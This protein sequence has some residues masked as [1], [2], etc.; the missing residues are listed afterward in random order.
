MAASDITGDNSSRRHTTVKGV[1]TAP[2]CSSKWGDNNVPGLSPIRAETLRLSPRRLVVGYANR[3]ICSSLPADGLQ[4]SLPAIL[5]HP[6]DCARYLRR[7]AE[8]LCE[9]SRYWEPIQRARAPVVEYFAPELAKA[10]CDQLSTTGAEELMRTIVSQ[11]D[12]L[13]VW[14]QSLPKL[15]R[16]KRRDLDLQGAESSSGMHVQIEVNRLCL[17]HVMVKA[18]LQLTNIRPLRQRDLKMKQDE[19]RRISAEATRRLRDLEEQFDEA[20]TEAADASA[21]VQLYERQLEYSLQTNRCMLRSCQ[22][23]SVP[24]ELFRLRNLEVLDLGN[25]SI[26]SIPPSVSK[27][28][29]LQKLLLDNNLIRTLPASLH[30]LSSSLTL[31]ALSGNPLDKQVLKLYLA[32]LPVLM[33]A[34]AS[35]GGCAIKPGGPHP[36]SVQKYMQLMS[37]TLPPTVVWRTFEDTEAR[38][39]EGRRV[40]ATRLHAATSLPALPRIPP[41][42]SP[43]S[44]PMQ[45]DTTD[46]SPR[47]L[48]FTASFELQSIPTSEVLF[49]ISSR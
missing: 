24:R 15:L 4:A 46:D 43:A 13:G 10:Q 30:N 29:S 18:L 39:F 42:P 9:S 14:G 19:V 27:L 38:S 28:Y 48:R 44:K 41:S 17:V 3:S 23:L 12:R 7:T 37:T 40:D 45:Q 25:N 26:Q 47:N 34:L 8:L 36:T 35:K 6:G 20:C 32:G 1:P 49:E 22:L 16:G 2:L 31:L 5:Q 21:I 11:P 33:E